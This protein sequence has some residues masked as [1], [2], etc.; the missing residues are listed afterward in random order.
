MSSTKTLF[1]RKD[2]NLT[3]EEE[4]LLME[5]LNQL[6]KSSTSD[7]ESSDSSLSAPS[8]SS[9]RSMHVERED[10]GKLSGINTIKEEE[11]SQGL[12]SGLIFGD[13]NSI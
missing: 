3:E 7:D 11:N 12:S 9:S 4:G 2:L 10:Y 8:G 5:S 6:R 1:D 13:E